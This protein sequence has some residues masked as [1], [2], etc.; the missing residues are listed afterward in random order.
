M[1]FSLVSASEKSIPFFS[2]GKTISVTYWF[3]LKYQI[4]SKQTCTLL[5]FLSSMGGTDLTSLVALL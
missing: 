2:L 5:V 4:H 3:P 1:A